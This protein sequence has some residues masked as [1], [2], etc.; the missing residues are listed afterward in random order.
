MPKN[1]DTKYSFKGSSGKKSDNKFANIYQDLIGREE[2]ME[3]NLLS[4]RHASMKS[5]QIVEDRNPVKEFDAETVEFNCRKRRQAV[6]NQMKSATSKSSPIYEI[7]DSSGFD[8]EENLR[9]LKEEKQSDKLNDSQLENTISFDTIGVRSIDDEIEYIRKKAKERKNMDK[10]SVEIYK[11]YSEFEKGD[12][13]KNSSDEEKTK[14][15]TSI[16]D[17]PTINKNILDE[18]T[19]RVCQDNTEDEIKKIIE[20]KNIGNINDYDTQKI[21]EINENEIKEMDKSIELSEADDI[22]LMEEGIKKIQKMQK[23]DGRK[24][25]SSKKTKKKNSKREEESIANKKNIREEAYRK[26]LSDRNKNSKRNKTIAITVILVFVVLIF[27]SAL[28]DR[29]RNNIP[30]FDN[31]KIE[32]K[33]EVKKPVKKKE[34]GKTDNKGDKKDILAKLKSMGS[35]LSDSENKRLQYIIDNIDSYP[36]DLLEK[37][38]RNPETLDYVYSYKDRDKYN[39]KSLKDV[40]TSYNVDGNVPYFL[41]WDRRWGY[42]NYGKEMIGLSGCGPTSLAMVIKYFDKDMDVNPYKIAKYSQENGYVSPKNFTS[43]RLFEDGLGKFGLT[44][45]DVIPVEAKMKRAL[46]NGDILIASVKPGI[47]TDRGHIIVIKGY[48]KNG[49]FLINDPNSII[50]TTKSWSFDEL[51]TQIR[52]IWAINRITKLD[53]ASKNSNSN[54]NSNNTNQDDPS[55]IQDIDN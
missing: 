54:N 11:E 12:I 1:N 27:S 33:K 19:N 35:N 47:F 28:L 48:N 41:Q 44:S 36:T 20:K 32:T 31:K 49:D 50:N 14:K 52:K 13:N 25:R 5:E 45:R 23:D 18:I 8:V 15:L 9:K 42:R 38:I 51:K 26:S 39:Q 43:W 6:V 4:K 7:N 21:K 16:D 46:D 55:I 10:S 29:F 40:T 34:E 37:L 53:N 17:I 22:R 30:F 2:A 3:E 24:T